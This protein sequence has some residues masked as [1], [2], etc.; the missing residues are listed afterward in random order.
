MFYP[1]ASYT[2]LHPSWHLLASPREHLIEL[3]SQ[4]LLKKNLWILTHFKF[5]HV[6]QLIV[7]RMPLGIAQGT[8]SY[9][10]RGDAGFQA[11]R[12]QRGREELV[13]ADST[14][15]LYADELSGCEP[16]VRLKRFCSLSLNSQSCQVLIPTDLFERNLRWEG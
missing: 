16:Q 4:D 15:N 13:S 11:R 12:S 2:L 3:H 6:H 1:W 5:A 14:R 8:V 10:G 7:G 9:E